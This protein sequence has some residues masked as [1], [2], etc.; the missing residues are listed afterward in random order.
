MGYVARLPGRDMSRHHH[1][2]AMMMQRLGNA[3]RNLIVDHA[4][5]GLFKNQLLSVVAH[6]E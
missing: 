3:D 1:A 5:E 6:D 4:H 2:V